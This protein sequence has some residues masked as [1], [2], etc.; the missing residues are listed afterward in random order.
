MTQAQESQAQQA[1]ACLHASFSE[2]ASSTSKQRQAQMCVLLCCS[3]QA[4][5]KKKAK[6]LDP[7]YALSVCVS[8][9]PGSFHTYSALLFPTARN[10]HRPPKTKN[11]NKNNTA[12]TFLPFCLFVL[13][14][15]LHL[16]PQITFLSRS[17]LPSQRRHT[18][19]SIIQ[20][21][22]GNVE[23]ILKGIPL[24]SLPP[25]PLGTV[26][27]WGGGEREGGCSF[28]CSF[29]VSFVF[30]FFFFFFFVIDGARL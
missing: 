14:A 18:K 28:R 10:A 3:W 6:T 22:A 21:M 7:K 26:K 30:F 29:F 1:L 17:S 23:Q 19:S 25:T 16:S 12:Q 13:L 8:D 5:A 2:R 20:N 11:N 15:S 27:V 9:L 24:S 4:K